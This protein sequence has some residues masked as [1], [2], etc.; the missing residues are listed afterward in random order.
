[1]RPK[2]AADLTQGFEPDPTRPATELTFPAAISV[3]TDTGI[4]M[5]A[6]GDLDLGYCQIGSTGV[7]LSAQDIVLRLSDVQPFPVGIAPAAFDLDPDWK[8]VFLGQVQ[9]FNLDALVEGLPKRLDLEKWFIGSGGVTGKAVATLDL[10]PDMS[11]QDFAVRAFRLAFERNALLESLVQLAVKVSFFDD[12]VL[13]LDLA[14]TNEPSL[15]FPDSMGF[16]G[17]IAGVQPSGGA[18]GGPARQ[19]E[20]I[21]MTASS[22]DTVLLRAGITKLGVR[23][24]PDKGRVKASG[25]PGDPEDTRYWDLM[26]D[27]R[28][29]IRPAATVAEST[30]GGEFT[31]LVL[32]V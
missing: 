28:L 4:Q 3:N 21:H 14:I 15:D 29:E 18:A 31:D 26:L 10:E 23:A 30:F 24:K 25:F 1:M 7:V 16:M 20:L 19:D 6:P 2:V 12:R 27:G 9:V 22:D 5:E 13:Y 8:G 32:Q 11:D 17:T